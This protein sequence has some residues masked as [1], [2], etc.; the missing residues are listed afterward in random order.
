MEENPTVKVLNLCWNSARAANHC[1][2]RTRRTAP[3]TH[4]VSRL[5]KR[6]LRDRERLLR[7]SLLEFEWAGRRWADPLTGTDV[8]RVSPEERL[9]FRN[10]Y[11]RSSMFTRD[12]AWMALMSEDPAGK[13]PPAIWCV[14]LATGASERVFEFSSRRSPGLSHWGFSPKSHL[15]HVID[16][17]DGR[18][19]IVQIDPDTREQRRIRPSEP[20]EGIAFGECSADEE[21]I[22]SHVSLKEIPE[23]TSNT[24]R[25]AMMG[26]EPGRNLMYR[27]SLADGATDVV[28]ETDAWWMGHCNPNPVDPNLF[29]CCQEG[30]IWTDRYPRPAN[31]QRQRIYDFARGAWLDLRGAM[32]SRGTHEHWSADGRRVYSHLHAYGCHTIY[33]TDL[34]A[35]KSTRYIGPPD[36]GISIHAAP[37]PDESFVI[38]DGFNFCRSDRDEIEG[39]QDF[40]GGDNPWSWDGMHTRSPGETIWLY[41]LPEDTVW[42][43]DVEFESNEHAHR[44]V[45]ENPEKTVRTRP[46]CRFRSLAKMKRLTMCLESNAHATPDSRWGVFQSAGE[47]GLFEV[48]AARVPRNAESG[49]SGDSH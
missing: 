16:R 17:A 32:R 24:E 39:A 34:D 19:E 13:A 8:V 48:W 27:I 21:Y 12:G 2:E 37:A 9:H 31:F 5:A 36:Y 4:N 10:P 38:G 14:N 28:F 1:V 29:M 20:L 15:L 23:G 43:E 42:G 22:F 26:S 3:L 41:E 49:E 18:A 44:A 30:F 47:E 45:S 40:G 6:P 7:M 33:V 46:L 25:I 35:G 11:F